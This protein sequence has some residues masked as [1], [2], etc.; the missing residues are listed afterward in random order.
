[1]PNKK[2]PATKATAV[3]NQLSYAELTQELAQ[4]MQQLEQ[5]ELD[6]DAA[7]LAYDRGL[8]IVKSLEADILKAENRVSQLRA[9]A[10]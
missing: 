7:V 1:M 8:V 4:L 3:V 6:L 5:G 2:L 10:S 9:E